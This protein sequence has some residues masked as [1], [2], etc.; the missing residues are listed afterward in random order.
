M[1]WEVWD[2]KGTGYDEGYEFMV[3]F[4][5]KSWVILRSLYV[6]I[7]ISTHSRVKVFLCSYLSGYNGFYKFINI[8]HPSSTCCMCVLYSIKQWQSKSEYIR[9]CVHIKYENKK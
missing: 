6:R 2:F 1:G 4:R 9:A 3:N 8:E 5:V 7:R